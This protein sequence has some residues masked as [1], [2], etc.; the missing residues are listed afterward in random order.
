M[1]HFADA[2]SNAN[3]P[4]RRAQC[5]RVLRRLGTRRGGPAFNDQ[6][7]VTDQRV[8]VMSRISGPLAVLAGLS[9]VMPAVIMLLSGSSSPTGAP[10]PV[11]VLE[12]LVGMALA[13]SA[14]LYW[15]VQYVRHHA[16]RPYQMRESRV[17]R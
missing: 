11:S 8:G 14:L 12:Y 16:P 5:D 4:S 17:R 3:G 10:P 6:E 9:L 7:A 13:G 15:G 2:K 1:F